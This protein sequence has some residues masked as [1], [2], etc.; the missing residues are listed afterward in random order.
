MRMWAGLDKE[1][2]HALCCPRARVRVGSSRRTG[3]QL[4]RLSAVKRLIY[5]SCGFKSFQRDASALLGLTEPAHTPLAATA[6]PVSSE[7]AA[8]GEDLHTPPPPPRRTAKAAAAAARTRSTSD[9][10]AQQEHDLADAAAICSQHLR[11]TQEEQA[12]RRAA[13]AG[14]GGGWSLVH[15]EGH[16]LFPGSDHLETLAIFDRK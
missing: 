4:T 10:A 16:V 1:V 3:S 6:A 8:A 7:H 12:Q 14:A 9:A 15:A 11:R 13:A 5:V 2:L